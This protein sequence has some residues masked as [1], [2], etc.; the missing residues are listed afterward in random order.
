MASVDRADVV[1][2]LTSSI[3]HGLAVRLNNLKTTQ[4]ISH[5]NSHLHDS[6]YPKIQDLHQYT[7]ILWY[8]KESEYQVQWQSTTGFIHI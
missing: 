3:H 2:C 5:I 7:V 1:N 8:Q 4:H 6:F